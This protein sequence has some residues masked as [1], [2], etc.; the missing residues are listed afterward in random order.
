MYKTKLR[1]LQGLDVPAII[2]VYPTTG[3]LQIAMEPPHPVFWTEAS[4]DMPYVLKHKCIRAYERIHAAGLLHGDVKLQ[5]MLIGADASVKI[6]DFS[7][8][9]SLRPNFR[10][11][12]EKAEKQDMRMEMR[13]VCFL[14]DANGARERERARVNDPA[15]APVEEWAQLLTEAPPKVFVMPGI[16]ADGLQQEAERFATLVERLEGG[17]ER[18]IS[19][20]LQR[21]HSESSG[22]FGP[23]KRPRSGHK[24]TKSEDPPHGAFAGFEIKADAVKDE[25]ADYA[26]CLAGFQGEEDRKSGILSGGHVSADSATASRQAGAHDNQH[27][28][29]G[30][31]KRDTDEVDP[32]LIIRDGGVKSARRDSTSRW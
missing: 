23:A 18:E 28:M 3:R 21:N 13:K 31:R 15:P 9:R 19:R 24:I 20:G 7:Q 10:L 29:S 6:I 14:L 30:K 16:T 4:A 27:R 25:D 12:I 8:S 22:I 1:N 32:D 2:N 5:H 26:N 17:P 11:R